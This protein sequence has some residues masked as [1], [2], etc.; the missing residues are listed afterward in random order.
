MPLQQ[1]AGRPSYAVPL[2]ISI[3]REAREYLSAI[4]GD[5]NVGRV[6]SRLILEERARAEERQRIA[7]LLASSVA[8]CKTS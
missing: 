5:K 3:D 6:V 8:M 2:N 4:T 7:A 1:Y